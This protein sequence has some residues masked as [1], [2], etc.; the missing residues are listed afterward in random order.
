MPLRFA[1]GGIV[2]R[3]GYNPLPQEGTTISLIPIHQAQLD[4]AI[5]RGRLQPVDA[6]RAIESLEKGL[7]EGRPIDMAEAIAGVAGLTNSQLE[8]LRR[9][10]MNESLSL[11]APPRPAAR[12]TPVPTR[13]S[14][15]KLVLA[16]GAIGAAV[17]VGS[18]LLVREGADSPSLP[19]ST[20]SAPERREVDSP[21]SGSPPE[22]SPPTEPDPVPAPGP[23]V[24]RPPEQEPPPVA[25]RREPRPVPVEVDP[26][27]V[28]PPVEALAHPGLLQG[29][30]LGLPDE[31][32]AKVAD[33]ERFPDYRR[34]ILDEL[35]RTSTSGMAYPPEADA[36]FE[37]LDGRLREMRNR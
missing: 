29:W 9:E 21:P 35:A 19:A 2:A 26:D 15:A 14:K 16:C 12:A 32:L 3:R 22:E 25:P 37:R 36:F 6:R 11:P 33:D 13:G 5:R 8:D 34:L 17:G 30:L 23:A 24:R 1:A 4:V 28:D 20:P 27:A 7:A 10:A 18:T 31:A